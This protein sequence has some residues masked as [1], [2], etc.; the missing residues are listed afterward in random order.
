M[1]P[2]EMPAAAKADPAA[3]KKTFEKVCSQC[4]ELTDVDAKPPRTPADV[5]KVLM[6]M[7]ENGLDESKETLEVVR[8]YL[9]ETYVHSR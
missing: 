7:V 4:H 6:R 8:A 1:T 3:V 5:D 2:G 9:L